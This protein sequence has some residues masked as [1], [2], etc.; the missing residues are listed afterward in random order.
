[1]YKCRVRKYRKTGRLQ[2]WHT[3]LLCEQLSIINRKRKRG[4]LVRERRRE[5]DAEREREREREMQQTWAAARVAVAG[6]EALRVA[7]PHDQ[8]HCVAT[9]RGVGEQPLQAV[10]PHVARGAQQQVA[11][12][13]PLRVESHRLE[14]RARLRIRQHLGAAAALS[15]QLH[16][17][18]CRELHRAATA[19]RAFV[20]VPGHCDA[21]S[22]DPRLSPSSRLS[23]RR[24]VN[25]TAGRLVQRQQKFWETQ[26]SKS[27][28]G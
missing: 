20:E 19:F 21:P 1:M 10:L 11:R 8:P 2:V 3:P 26:R 23:P 25:S 18:N 16:C 9:L 15:H 17:R 12:L 14:R 27:N 7:R 4:V 6:P 28:S 24:F 22:A 13:G 5:R